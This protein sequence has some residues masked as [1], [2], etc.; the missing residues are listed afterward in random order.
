MTRPTPLFRR[1]A[2]VAL[3][4]L[5][6][7]GAL[8]AAAL[9]RIAPEQSVLDAGGEADAP[10]LL[11]DSFADMAEGMAVPVEPDRAETTPVAPHTL[12]P[13]PAETQQPVT[14][15]RRTAALPQVAAL[16]PVTPEAM[17]ERPVET[18]QP[19]AVEPLRPAA[20]AERAEAAPPPEALRRVD[21]PPEADMALVDAP[22]TRPR[23]RP[24][25]RP[26]T[27][28]ETSPQR[29]A[30]TRTEPQPQAKPRPA[31]AGNAQQSARRGS[32]QGTE[33]GR[34]QTA[35][36]AQPAP[37]N[38][39]SAR[40][41]AKYGQDVMRKIARTRKARSAERGRAVVGFV[42]ADSGALGRVAIVQSSG[43]AKLDAQA[44]DHIRRAAPF[45]PPPAGAP[46]NL[47]VEITGR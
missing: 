35:A 1:S 47:S 7:S 45:P 31:P 17:P 13:T 18:V 32:T 19:L 25:A 10:P 3:T 33:T 30:E 16:A 39:G 24:E 8:H 22:S 11:G 27:R 29:Q 36:A 9:L 21:P 37:G 42:I 23:A 6:I 41:A 46:R 5:G 26:K 15:T 38:G 12:T 2:L 4:A 34:S 44:L 20:P 43:S 14:D 28:S 40:A